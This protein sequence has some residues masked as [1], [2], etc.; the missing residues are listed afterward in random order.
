MDTRFEQFIKSKQY[1]LGVTQRTVDCIGT[2]CACCRQNSHHKTTLTSL[3]AKC[4]KLA[5]RSQALIV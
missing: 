5:T 2:R 1:L 4:K 3:Y